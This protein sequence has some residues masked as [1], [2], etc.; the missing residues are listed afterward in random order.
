MRACQSPST[1]PVWAIN[2]YVSAMVSF[3][4]RFAFVAM[5]S[6]CYGHDATTTTS[7]QHAFGDATCFTQVIR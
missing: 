7:Q 1:S 6:P 4:L 5:T 2:S 3:F